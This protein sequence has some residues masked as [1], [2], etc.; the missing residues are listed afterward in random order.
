[1]EE[2]VKRKNGRQNMMQAR[3]EGEHF[4]YEEMEEARVFQKMRLRDSVEGKRGML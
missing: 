4:I 3:V 1:M 2:E